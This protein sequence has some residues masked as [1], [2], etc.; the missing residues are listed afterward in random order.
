MRWGTFV[1]PAYSLCRCGQARLHRGVRGGGARSPSAGR[2]AALPV[3]D[4]FDQ[5]DAGDADA[6]AL[7]A[8]GFRLRRGIRH[9]RH[10]P[11]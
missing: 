4:V 7:R 11:P 2:P 5:P 8:T 1:D 9:P 10:R 3:L 6:T